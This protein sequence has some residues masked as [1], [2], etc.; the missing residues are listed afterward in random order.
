[1]FKPVEFLFTPIRAFRKIILIG[2]FLPIQIFGQQIP[3]AD[4]LEIVIQQCLNFLK[5]AQKSTTVADSHF[6]GE[7]PSFMEMRT[8]YILLGEQ[9]KSIR[10]K[11]FCPCGDDEHSC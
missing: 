2:L 10:F 4:S 8:G 3:S 6:A 9:K 5:D 1:M 11:L 7:W